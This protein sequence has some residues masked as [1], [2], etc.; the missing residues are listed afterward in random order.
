MTFSI[1]AHA[2]TPREALYIVR[3]LLPV[4]IRSTTNLTVRRTGN[5]TFEVYA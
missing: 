4:S 2:A 1:T 3:N 5:S